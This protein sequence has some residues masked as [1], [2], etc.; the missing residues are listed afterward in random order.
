MK[1][2]LES[3]KFYTVIICSLILYFVIANL[4]S[5]F[6]SVFSITSYSVI[7]P[8]EI[9]Y[10][11]I[12][13]FLSIFF[14]FYLSKLSMDQLSIQLKKYLIGFTS[15]IV[16]F[17]LSSFITIPLMILN[18]DIQNM[19]QFFKVIYSIFYDIHSQE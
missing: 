16:Y 18:I 13:F 7:A 8:F 1:Y 2:K 15:I 12:A 11:V 3:F 4:D 6:L 9:V 5:F 10:Q 19:S 14:G 17:S